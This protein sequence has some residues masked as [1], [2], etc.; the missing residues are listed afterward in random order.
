VGNRN[1]IPRA[2]DVRAA[3]CL[4][5]PAKKR[6]GAR[7]LQAAPPSCGQLPVGTALPRPGGARAARVERAANQRTRSGPRIKHY[8]TSRESM[9]DAGDGGVS[10]LSAACLLTRAALMSRPLLPQ[11]C[12]HS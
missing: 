5:P 7:A 9:I 3:A 6:M 8:M 10:A 11:H 12:D 2:S 4:R 1:V